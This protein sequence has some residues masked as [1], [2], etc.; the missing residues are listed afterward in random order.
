MDVFS[1][2]KYACATTISDSHCSFGSQTLL[3]CCGDWF[4]E[5]AI[6]PGMSTWKQNLRTFA[7]CNCWHPYWYNDA[8]QSRGLSRLLWRRWPGAIFTQQ[9]QLDELWSA[10]WTIP[11]FRVELSF[12]QLLPLQTEVTILPQN[13][14]ELR[15][16]V[17]SGWKTALLTDYA[18]Q[19]GS[20]YLGEP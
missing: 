17:S 13:C 7:K 11:R 15:T 10:P 18:V 6:A 5:T 1:L 16:Y 8:I 3:N 9:P 4:K 12:L 20:I 19:H 14:R 2:L